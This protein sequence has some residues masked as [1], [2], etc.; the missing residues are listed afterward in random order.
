MNPR[1]GPAGPVRLEPHRNGGLLREA[2]RELAVESLRLVPPRE[3]ATGL[4]RRHDLVDLRALGSPSAEDPLAPSDPAALEE[5]GPIA[6]SEPHREAAD[7]FDDGPN[8]VGSGGD[9]CVALDL[10]HAVTIVH[11]PAGA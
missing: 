9:R 6:E 1:I 4:V 3:Q 7:V 11:P 8:G 2:R 10:D 5:L